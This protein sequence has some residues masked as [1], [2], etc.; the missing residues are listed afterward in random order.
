MEN[1]KLIRRRQLL[2]LI[3]MSHTTQWRLERAGRFPARVRI[4]A[5]S[6]GWHL[7][8]VEEWVRERERVQGGAQQDRGAGTLEA[9]VTVDGFRGKR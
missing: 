8:E 5:G 3:G 6:V 2:E 4:G 1:D 9:G 7:A